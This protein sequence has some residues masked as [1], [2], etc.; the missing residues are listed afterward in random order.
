MSWIDHGIC[1]QIDPGLW[2]PEQG[3]SSAEAKRLCLTCP[4]RLACREYALSLPEQ[5]YGV[6]GGLTERERRIERRQRA[7]ENAA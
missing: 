7:K 2:F 5:I 6:W 4:V 3:E 1:S